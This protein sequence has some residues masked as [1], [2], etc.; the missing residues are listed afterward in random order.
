M[1]KLH[2]YETWLGAPSHGN[3]VL[4]LYPRNGK[5][6]LLLNLIDARD[7]LLLLNL[8]KCTEQ[9][10]TALLIVTLHRVIGNL[11]DYKT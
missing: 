6:T 8:V 5:T 10:K 4:L 3:T 1:E 11:Y 2:K 9:W 7:H